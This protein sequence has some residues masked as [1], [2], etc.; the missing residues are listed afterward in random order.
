MQ[1]TGGAPPE[2][3]EAARAQGGEPGSLDN[4]W[5]L[6]H[7]QGVRRVGARAGPGRRATLARQKRATSTLKALSTRMT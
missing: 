5:G 3:A 7:T 4:T 2:D 6:T 1:R